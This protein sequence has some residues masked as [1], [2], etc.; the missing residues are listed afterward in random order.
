MKQRESVREIP[1]VPGNYYLDRDL[2]N[3]F[4]DVIYNG[5]NEK[6]SILD[7]SRRINS[8]IL[9]KRKELGLG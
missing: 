4:R 3:A 1:Q 5:R 6:E 8:E 7:Y 2:L 9:R